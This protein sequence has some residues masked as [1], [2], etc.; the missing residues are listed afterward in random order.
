MLT[1]VFIARETPLSALSA[2]FAG[3]T[4]VGVL[5][6][7]NLLYWDQDVIQSKVL[8]YSHYSMRIWGVDPHCGNK[9]CAALPGN[10][11]FTLRKNKRGDGSQGYARCKCLECDWETPWIQRPDWLIPQGVHA[12]FIHNFPLS[13]IQQDIFASQM[14]SVTGL[15]QDMDLT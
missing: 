5:T 9:K 15:D 14:A 1:K 10:M 13:H 3:N 6:G 4:R 8:V 12:W 2:S 11:K 7:V